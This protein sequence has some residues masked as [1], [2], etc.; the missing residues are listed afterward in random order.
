[1]RL[2]NFLNEEVVLDINIGDVIL[3][4]RFKNKRVT[5]KNIEKNEKGDW[6]VNGKPL[7]KYRIPPKLEPEEEEIQDEV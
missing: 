5:V 2:K 4:G 7:L 3:G 1:M 6:L